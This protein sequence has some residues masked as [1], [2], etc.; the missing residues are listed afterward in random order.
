MDK[1]ND[2]SAKNL[3]GM[4]HL[5]SSIDKSEKMLPLIGRHMKLMAKIHRTAYEA[6]IKEGFTSEQALDLCSRVMRGN[7]QG[8]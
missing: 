8:G 7:D 2:Q 3:L 4:I 6:Y 5:E 1:D